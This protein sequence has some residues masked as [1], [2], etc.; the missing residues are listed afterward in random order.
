MRKDRQT[1]EPAQR[2]DFFLIKSLKTKREGNEFSE[3]CDLRRKET[4]NIVSFHEFIV[5]SCVCVERCRNVS[6]SSGDRTSL[7]G[8]RK[9]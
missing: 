8:H 4:R 2:E 6:K 1:F 9:T 5:T 3:N 7:G